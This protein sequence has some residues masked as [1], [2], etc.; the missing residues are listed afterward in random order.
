MFIARDVKAGNILVNSDGRVRLA[1]FGAACVI[2][3]RK[4]SSEVEHLVGTPCWMAPEVIGSQQYDCQVCSTMV[5]RGY[6]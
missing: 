4:G 5:F 1:D 3:G 2:E 6:R